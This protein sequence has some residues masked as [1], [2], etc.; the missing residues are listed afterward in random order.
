MSRNTMIVLMYHRYNTLYLIFSIFHFTVSPNQRII[1]LSVN[2]CKCGNSKRGLMMLSEIIVVY[3]ENR[4]IHIN[5]GSLILYQ[6]VVVVTTV[7]SG[8]KVDTKRWDWL[9]IMPR[10]GLLY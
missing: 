3:S 6:T 2:V 7:F 9:K 8:F 1:K 4:T 10:A 5:A